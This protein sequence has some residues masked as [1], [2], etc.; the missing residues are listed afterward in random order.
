MTVKA[1]AKIAV[2]GQISDDRNR[3]KGDVTSQIS[4]PKKQSEAVLLGV[5]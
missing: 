2:E 5:D 4:R 1:S 3:P